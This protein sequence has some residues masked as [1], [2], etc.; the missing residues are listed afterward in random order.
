VDRDRNFSENDLKLIEIF[1][2]NTA[3]AINDARLY[4]QVSEFNKKLEEKVR[5][6]TRMLDAANRIKSNFLSSVSHELRTPLNA[7]VGFSKVLLDKNFGPLNE[8]QEKYT[9]N[10][11]D[12]GQRLDAIIDDILDVSKLDAGSLELDRSAFEVNVLLEAFKTHFKENVHEKQLKFELQVQDD[13]AGMEIVAD[14]LKL[15]QVAGHLISNAVKFTP[16]NGSIAILTKRVSAVNV[17]GSGSAQVS[18][19]DFL[20]ITVADTGI[21]VA[22]EDQ[23]EIFKDFYQVK[24]GLTG[25]SSGTGMGLSLAKRL[26]ELHG[27]KIWVESDGTDQGS[28][29]KFVIPTSI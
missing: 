28:Q 9:Q 7:I 1:A 18:N 14:S 24:S 23:T 26:V 17:I 27:G 12:S 11:A 29:F 21:G 20:E 2:N 13:L 3:V 5:Q 16:E 6:R 15:Q 8:R 4:K 19:G 10:I 22:L 25:K